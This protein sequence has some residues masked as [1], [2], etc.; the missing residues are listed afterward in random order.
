M[1][2]TNEIMNDFIYTL[3][4]LTF[5][6]AMIGLCAICCLFYKEQSMYKRASDIR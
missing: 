2:T 3:N 1:T 6:A 5:L 4:L